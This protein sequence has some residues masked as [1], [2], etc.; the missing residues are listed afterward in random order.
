MEDR[1]LAVTPDAMVDYFQRAI[2]SIGSVLAHFVFNADETWHQELGDQHKRTRFVPYSIPE[3]KS[4]ILCPER[5]NELRPLHVYPPTVP[6][7]RPL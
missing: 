5:A 6:L 7:R 2:E 3:I 1:R 4:A